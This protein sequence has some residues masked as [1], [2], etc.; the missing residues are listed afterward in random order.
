MDGLDTTT[1]REIKSILLVLSKALPLISISVKSRATR[2]SPNNSHS[3]Y[4]RAR[5]ATVSTTALLSG[6]SKLQSL[7]TFSSATSPSRSKTS[8]R[9][10]STP[11]SQRYTPPARKSR[12]NR[13]TPLVT[14]VKDDAFLLNPP[15]PSNGE[16]FFVKEAV[17]AFDA[18]EHR[19]KKQL[20]ELGLNKKK[21]KEKLICYWHSM[22]WAP[23]H[24]LSYWY[25]LVKLLKEGKPLR[26][27]RKGKICKTGREPLA[28]IDDIMDFVNEFLRERIEAQLMFL[29]LS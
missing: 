3:S 19:N 9:K 23:L 12:G 24:N 27:W 26:E 10:I 14:P 18:Y 22:G 5:I 6:T 29:L 2:C 1:A 16:Y 15:S 8:R 13:K 20:K 7:I 28:E 17:E 4:A 11:I 25:R 21:I